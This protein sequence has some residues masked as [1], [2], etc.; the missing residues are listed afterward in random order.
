VGAETDLDLTRW[1]VRW[2]NEL[3]RL[4]VLLEAELGKRRLSGD[5][6]LLF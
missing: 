4:N 6:E 3:Q 1:D 5:P 2:N